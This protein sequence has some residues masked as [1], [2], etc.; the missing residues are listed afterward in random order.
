MQNISDLKWIEKVLSN[1]EHFKLVNCSSV[2]CVCVSSLRNLSLLLLH[3]PAIHRRIP[4]GKKDRIC[5]QEKQTTEIG[6]CEGK[7]RLK[8]NRKGKCMSEIS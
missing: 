7:I 4:E 6:E 5:L 2:I 1:I 8:R 3:P